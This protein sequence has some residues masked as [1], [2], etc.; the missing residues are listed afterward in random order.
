MYFH[1]KQNCFLDYFDDPIPDD[2]VIY[3]SDIP[4]Q[5]KRGQV[6]WIHR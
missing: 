2:A 4:V 5:W 3:V 6:Y 1:H